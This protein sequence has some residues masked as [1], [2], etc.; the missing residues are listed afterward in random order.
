MTT[1]SIITATYNSDVTVRDCLQSVASQNHPVEHIIIDGASTDNTLN[2][3]RESSQNSRVFSESDSGMYEAMNKGIALATGEIIGILNADDFYATT[4]VLTKVARTF[5]DSSVMCCYGDLEYVKRSGDRGNF[6]VV[7]YWRSGTFTTRSFYWGWMPPHPTFFVRRCVYENY[8]TFR[9]NM[10]SAAD[11]E[12]MLR[13]L[14]K[15]G[16]RVTYI[17]EVLV[18]MRIGGASNESLTARVIANGMD[19]RAWEVN[20]LKAYPWTFFL[21]PFRKLG[22]FLVRQRK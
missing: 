9:L 8:G 2:I 22:Q 15:H 3:V 10:G 12:L 14:L 1:I 4:D 11:Y 16:L 7:R 6:D 13:L 21:K 19:R 18:R 5:K 20:E 17:P